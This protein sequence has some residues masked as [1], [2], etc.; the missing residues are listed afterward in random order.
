M[1][2]NEFDIVVIGAGIAGCAAA[3]SLSKTK[4]VLIIE[5]DFSE[6]DRIGNPSPKE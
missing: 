5:R 3:Y 1:E 6:P 2:V 4:R